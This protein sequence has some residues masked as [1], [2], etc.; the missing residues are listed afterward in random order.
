MATLLAF[1]SSDAKATR[2]EPYTQSIT[3]PLAIP[4]L[5]AT[6]VLGGTLKNDSQQWHR[7]VVKPGDTLSALFIQ[8]GLRQKTLHRIMSLGKPTKN[9]KFL[10]PGQRF[11]FRIDAENVLQELLFMPNKISTLRILRQADTFLVVAIEH[12]LEKRLSY[13]TSE[14]ESSLFE[15]GSAA[16]MSDALIM[17][18]ANIFGWDID[19][20]L[21]IRSGDHFSILYEEHFLDGKKVNNGPILIA[22]FTNQGRTY[23]AVRFT[24]VNGQS[25]YYNPEGLSMR[26]AF[27]RAPVDFKRISSR[28]GRRHHPILHRMRLH[29]GVDYS[30]QTGTSIKA[31]GDGKVIYRGRKGAYGRTIIIKHGGRYSTLYA[32]MSGY[33]RGITVGKHV[34]QGQIIGYVG[35]SGR[36]TGPHLHYEFR[37]NGVHRNPLKV[38]LPDAKP[39]D[40]RYK[41]SFQDHTGKLLAQLEM[42]KQTQLAMHE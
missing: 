38:R 13:T 17:E 32:H 24:H 29:K 14:I 12:K 19:F 27:L 22:E 37:I 34:R 41:K 11:N 8:Q 4:Q 39:I 42:Y 28:F 16:G 30:A 10:V 20:A 7:V 1:L 18:L 36:T 9:L 25:D 21:D 5:D 31:S 15:A 26:K 33:K 3:L 40:K 6:H 35:Q 2:H 23:Q